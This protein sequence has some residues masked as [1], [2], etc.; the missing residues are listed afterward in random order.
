MISNL[1]AKHWL[2]ETDKLKDKFESASPFKHLILDNFFTQ[3]FAKELL[4][5]F[6]EFDQTAALNENGEIGMKATQERVTQLG[7]AYKRLDALAKSEEFLGFVGEITG[8]SDLKFDPH[9]FGGGT[10]EN[11]EGQDLDLHVDFNYHPIS[12]QHRRLN[13]IV[14]FNEEW[15]DDWGGSLEL[16]RNPRDWEDSC[17]KLV[18][19]LFNRCVIFET[20]ESSW[21]GFER[22]QLPEDRKNLSRKSFALYFYTV[23]RPAEEVAGTHSTIY[24]ERP[25]PAK[26][27]PGHTLSEPEVQQLKQMLH[28]RDQ[29]IDRL[30][31]SVHSLIGR[32]EKLEKMRQQARP[33]PLRWLAALKR[34][35]FK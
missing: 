21:H 6:P 30:Y 5:Q 1:V 22:I 27:Q 32:V 19:P 33:A 34:R 7:S 9:Y 4:E 23:E 25:L 24:V 13:L 29:H 12:G 35:L 31:N 18:T 15:Q 16:A 17:R 10:H 3:V 14:Y 20:T 28:R 11:L 8:I 2:D 26:Y